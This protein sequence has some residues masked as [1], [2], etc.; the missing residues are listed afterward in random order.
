MSDTYFIGRLRS[1]NSPLS[2]QESELVLTLREQ[3]ALR[4]KA[5][6][7]EA[8]DDGKAARAGQNLPGGTDLPGPRPTDPDLTPEKISTLLLVLQTLDSP[9]D[10]SLRRSRNTLADYLS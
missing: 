8:E 2:L 6:R 10:G 9:R 3:P 4:V 1:V 7:P 5:R